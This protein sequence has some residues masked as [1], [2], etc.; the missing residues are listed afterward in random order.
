MNFYP[1]NTFLDLFN[2]KNPDQSRVANLRT[3]TLAMQVQT[4]PLEGPRIL[5]EGDSTILHHHLG[6][7]LSLLESQE[8]NPSTVSAD[9]FDCSI[10]SCITYV[11]N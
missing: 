5:K 7:A 10:Y 2:P 1:H 6:L 9:D 11:E 4:L 8:G 3:G